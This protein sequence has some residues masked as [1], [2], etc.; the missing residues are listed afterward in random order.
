MKLLLGIHSGLELARDA[1]SQHVVG[2]KGDFFAGLG[3][4]ALAVLLGEGFEL[5]ET[6]QQHFL[7]FL[8]GFLHDSEHGIQHFFSVLLLHLGLGANRLGDICFGDG[9]AHGFFSGISLC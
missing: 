4:A 7:L 3:V 2:V 9:F 5:A 6:A 8:E 1:E